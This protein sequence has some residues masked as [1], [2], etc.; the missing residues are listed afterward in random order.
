MIIGFAGKAGSGKTECARYLEKE[1]GAIRLSFASGVR[2]EVAEFFKSIGLGFPNEYLCSQEGKKKKIYFS[3]T[4]SV[5]RCNEEYLKFLNNFLRRYAIIEENGYLSFTGRQILQWWGTDLRRNQNEDYWID[6]IEWDRMDPN[7]I[8]VFDDT[9]YP[10][11][12]EA[13]TSRHG[14]LVLVVRENVPPIEGADHVSENAL[15]SV[16]FHCAIRN[17]KSID[18]LHSAL[19]IIMASIVQR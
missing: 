4:R 5:R 17:E 10:N 2:Q 1:Y 19:D 13:I 16:G 8:Y 3:I 12:C 14:L 11:E 9:R 7:K 18:A 15:G 6:K